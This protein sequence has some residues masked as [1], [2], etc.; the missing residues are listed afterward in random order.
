MVTEA[1]QVVEAAIKYFGDVLP[2]TGIR[3][4]EIEL[5]NDER[6]WSIT[7]SGLLPAA[8]DLPP[9]TP[10][11][12]ADIFKNPPPERV[13]KVFVVEDQACRV[14]SMKIRSLALEPQ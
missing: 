7:L 1:K 9:G 14:K 5:S 3:L 10:L 8:K 6:F 12:M 11:T 13:Y 2:A 4:E